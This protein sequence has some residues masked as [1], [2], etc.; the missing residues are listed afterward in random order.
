MTVLPPWSSSLCGQEPD[1]TVGLSPHSGTSTLC[2]L[3]HSPV[4]LV[5]HTEEW[6][7]F[8]HDFSSSLQKPGQGGGQCT[9]RCPPST[10]SSLNKM[11]TWAAG[12]QNK[13]VAMQ[14]NPQWIKV[15]T[16][17]FHLYS[18]HIFLFPPHILC[19]HSP[20]DKTQF[21]HFCH[22]NKWQRRE[23][24]DGFLYISSLDRIN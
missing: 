15:I 4:P 5:V 21:M 6:C 2:G 10:G 9:T 16:K 12:F 7:G 22:E 17:L 8:V 13:S 20:R 24:Y 19:M 23:V 1:R 11:H 3:S 14:G 18:H